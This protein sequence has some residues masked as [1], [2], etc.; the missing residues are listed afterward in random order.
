MVSFF[1]SKQGG[2]NEGKKTLLNDK[3]KDYTKIKNLVIDHGAEGT[4]P[5][6]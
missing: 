1:M 2:K 4:M 5:G 6:K 3:S